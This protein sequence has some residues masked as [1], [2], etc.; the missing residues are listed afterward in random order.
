M[1]GQMKYIIVDDGMTEVVYLF[2]N[3]VPHN[4]M[5]TQVPGEVV[6]AGFVAH[7]TEGMQCYGRSTSLD[8]SSRGDVDSG[9]INRELGIDNS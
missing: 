8:I 4:H 2:S 6:G 7:T 5:A 3:F 9:Y 1:F